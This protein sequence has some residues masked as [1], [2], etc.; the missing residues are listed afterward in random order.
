[1]ADVD[2]LAFVFRFPNL[3][4]LCLGS[5]PIYISRHRSEQVDTD[6]YQSIPIY[7]SRHRSKQVDTDLNQLTPILHNR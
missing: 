5:T 6:L 2:N 4:A 3:L 7:I 1:P